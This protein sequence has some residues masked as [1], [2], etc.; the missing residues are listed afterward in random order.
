MS[1][2]KSYKDLR[3]WQQSLQ[4]VL[5]VYKLSETLP[6]CER[7]GLTSQMRRSAVSVPSNIAEGYGRRSTNDYKRFLKISQGSLY[8]LET[9]LIIANELKMI[10]LDSL[11]QA[12]SHIDSINK[13]TNK[14]ISAL[15][16]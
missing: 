5:L 7:F 16:Q 14:L 12:S 13:M 3:I 11:N 10:S 2:I 4:L 8:E 15:D 6:D 9:Q 1:E